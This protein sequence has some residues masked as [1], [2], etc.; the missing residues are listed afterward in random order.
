ML[1]KKCVFI[2][3][4]YNRWMENEEVG[5]LERKTEENRREGE[6]FTQWLGSPN[7]PFTFFS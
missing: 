1:K 2:T 3:L 6:L 7:C 4:L 5:H